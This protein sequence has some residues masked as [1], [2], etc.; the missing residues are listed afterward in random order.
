V[1][2][3]RAATRAEVRRVPEAI[4]QLK[5]IDIIDEPGSTSIKNVNGWHIDRSPRSFVN[6]SVQSN[7]VPDGD[8]QKFYE[9]E[10][11][12]AYHFCLKLKSIDS[13]GI[14]PDGPIVS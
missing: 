2:R 14:E 7:V 5:V 13:S 12:V 8:R 11:I 10:F 9:F 1:G 4:G 6:L 3:H